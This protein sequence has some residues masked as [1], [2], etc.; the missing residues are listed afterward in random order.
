MP[1]RGDNDIRNPLRYRNRPLPSLMRFS[2]RT[3][4]WRTPEV[5]LAQKL[6]L[7]GEDWWF[8]QVSLGGFAMSYRL[9]FCFRRVL[10]LQKCFLDL[11]ISLLV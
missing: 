5:T 9:S 6:S 10:E 4:K 11:T 3:G 8:C 2:I 1:R 7:A